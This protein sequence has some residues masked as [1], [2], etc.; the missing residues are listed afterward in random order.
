MLRF[1]SNSIGRESPPKK[2]EGTI[3]DKNKV[4]VLPYK[5]SSFKDIIIQSPQSMI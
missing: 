2:F 4:W 5:S 3:G 1:S